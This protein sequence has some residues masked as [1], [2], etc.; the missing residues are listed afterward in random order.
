MGDVIQLPTPKEVGEDI[1]PNVVLDML[2]KGEIDYPHAHRLMMSSEEAMEDPEWWN[3]ELIRAYGL[4]NG[5]L[6]VGPTFFS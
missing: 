5:R 2:T 1:N 6:F 4:A 3:C